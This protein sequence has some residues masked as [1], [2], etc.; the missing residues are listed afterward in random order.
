[1]VRDAARYLSAVVAEYRAECATGF[2]NDYDARRKLWHCAVVVFEVAENP[3]P[4][5][6]QLRELSLGHVRPTQI[7]TTIRSAGLKAVGRGR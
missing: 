6:D 4:W 2:S 3:E 5:L 7:E 1:M